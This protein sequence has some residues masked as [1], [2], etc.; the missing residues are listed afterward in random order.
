MVYVGAR[1]NG[2]VRAELKGITG[3]QQYV[4]LEES[5]NNSRNTE[6]NLSWPTNWVVDALGRDNIMGVDPIRLGI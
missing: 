1:W 2:E 4:S 5:K 3:K 6:W